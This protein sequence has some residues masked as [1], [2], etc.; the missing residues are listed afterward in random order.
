MLKTWGIDEVRVKGKPKAGHAGVVEAER[1]T[2]KTI[3]NELKAKFADVIDDP[4]MKAIMKA[5][6][7][8]LQK[9]LSGDEDE[10][11]ST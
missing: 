6:S 10:K 5:A 1:E 8:Q 4:V 9:N 11:E 2:K 3:E 7:K